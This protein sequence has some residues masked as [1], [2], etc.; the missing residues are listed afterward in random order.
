M[1]LFGDF[2]PQTPVAT[3]SDRVLKGEKALN[4]LTTKKGV[5][6]G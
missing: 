2:D 5:L 3:K 1:L 6:Y 4:A